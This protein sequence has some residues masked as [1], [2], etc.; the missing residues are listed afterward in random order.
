M[1][2]ITTS[3]LLLALAIIL[4]R[5]AHLTPWKWAKREWYLVRRET[6]APKAGA[7]TVE[8]DPRVERM[9]AKQR[10]LGKRM[11]RDG[12]TLHNPARKYVP[13]LTKPAEDPPP[14]RANKVV[15]IRKSQR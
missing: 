5:S 6:W 14:P 1:D 9:D 3:L 10:A 2:F 8:G 13:V 4:A 7:G 11:R 15:P 12:R